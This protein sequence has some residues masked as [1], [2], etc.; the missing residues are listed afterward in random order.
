MISI[1][2]SNKVSI[3]GMSIVMMDV[4]FAI[5]E[6]QLINEEGCDYDTAVNNW[7]RGFYW[8]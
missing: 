4:F 1:K 5:M 3:R 2:H 6:T 8:N 7:R